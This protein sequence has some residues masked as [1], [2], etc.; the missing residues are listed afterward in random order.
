MMN[1]NAECS[2]FEKTYDDGKITEL[3]CFNLKVPDFEDSPDN[4]LDTVIHPSSDWIIHADFDERVFGD[5]E[6]E[7]ELSIRW[8]CRMSKHSTLQDLLDV[9]E[10]KPVYG[11]FE[12][13]DRIRS[14]SPVPVYRLIWGT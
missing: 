10:N 11:Y 1:A 8:S 5:D 14:N 13:F 9:I 2:C 3:P 7:G 4:V 12:G 6:F